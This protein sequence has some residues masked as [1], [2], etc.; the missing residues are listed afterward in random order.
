[1]IGLHAVVNNPSPKEIRDRRKSAGLTQLAAGRLVHVTSRTWQ[2][3][4]LGTHPM[5]L[6]LWELFNLKISK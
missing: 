1:M 2:A 4:E 3:W 6:A 5:G